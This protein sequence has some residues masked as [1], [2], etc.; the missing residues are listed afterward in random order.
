MKETMKDSLKD[1]IGTRKEEK[2]VRYE[3]PEMEIIEF[4]AVRT[5]VV[6]GSTID[7]KPDDEDI[8]IF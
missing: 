7:N 3:E 2:R 8:T 5:T 1:M 4:G 6:E